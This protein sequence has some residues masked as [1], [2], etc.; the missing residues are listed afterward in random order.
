[1]SEERFATTFARKPARPSRGIAPGRRVWTTLCATAVVTAAVAG[2]GTV[3][4]RL[5]APDDAAPVSAAAPPGERAEE[6]GPQQPPPASPDASQDADDRTEE[7]AEERDEP[8]PPD[9]GAPDPAPRAPAPPAAQPDAGTGTGADPGEQRPADEPEEQPEEPEPRADPE[10]PP[11]APA[12]TGST[13]HLIGLA[14]KCAEVPATSPGTGSQLGT[15][16]DSANQRWLVASDGTLRVAGQCLAL[17]GGAT[18]DG[19]RAVL[20]ACNPSDTRQHWRI[21]RAAGD[22]VNVAADK[23]LDVAHAD[24]TDGTPLQIAWCSGNSAQ[25]WSAP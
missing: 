24:P 13:G 2:T 23:C 21:E 4:A 14:G 5:L 9:P 22:V 19:T 6:P 20:A 12:V 25:K 15:C 10:P 16:S 17:S 8:A 1:M 3:A 18:S 7:P 11:A